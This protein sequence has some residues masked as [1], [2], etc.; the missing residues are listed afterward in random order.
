[1]DKPKH[2]EYDA[3]MD[4]FAKTELFPL[5]HQPLKNDAHERLLSG[6]GGFQRYP[7][8]EN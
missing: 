8:T 7:L 4:T 5:H 3:G 1:M 2:K 6:S